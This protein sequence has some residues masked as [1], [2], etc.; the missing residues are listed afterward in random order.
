[1]NS[2][3]LLRPEKL[4]FID[5]SGFDVKMSRRYGRA[6]VGTAC[7]G[8]VPFGRWGN[9]TFIAGLRVGGTCAP[10]LM[11]GAMNGAWF[12]HWIETQLAPTLSPGDIVSCGNLSV[13][14]N[15]GAR[16]AIKRKGAELRFLPPYS[17]DLNPI[18]QVAA[19]IKGI[20]RGFA[21]RCFDTLCDAI[22]TALHA[23]SPDECSNYLQNA[24][25]KPT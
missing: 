25:Y 9:N 16:E 15:K 8:A 17:P 14:K 6:Q 3:P 13:H 22:K 10:M 18:E 2:H 19:K 1:M 7:L 21:P 12:C 23:I 4:I 5:E 11:Q 24:R 20:V